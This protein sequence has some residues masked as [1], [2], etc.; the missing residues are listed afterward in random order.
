[1]GLGFPNRAE[2][3][4][5]GGTPIASPACRSCKSIK[6]NNA[7]MGTYPPRGALALCTIPSK[8]AIGQWDWGFYTMRSGFGPRDHRFRPR[9]VGVPFSSPGCRSCKG[10]E[11]FLIRGWKHVPSAVPWF[12]VRSLDNHRPASGAG[13]STPCGAGATREITVFVPLSLIHI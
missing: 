5:P 7:G 13:V 10:M 6:K 12:D 3:C 1:M 11:G 9:V 4:R 2:R 8:S